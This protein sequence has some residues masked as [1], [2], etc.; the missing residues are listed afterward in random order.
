MGMLER[1]SD[2]RGT[3][4]GKIVAVVL[5]ILLVLPVATVTAF[6]NSDAEEKAK[7]ETKTEEVVDEQDVVKQDLEKPDTGS[8]PVTIESPTK[9]TKAATINIKVTVNDDTGFYCNGVF[10]AH[11]GDYTV[12]DIPT[13]APLYFSAFGPDNTPATV[14]YGGVPLTPTDSTGTSYYIPEEKLDSRNTIV[15]SKKAEATTPD[16]DE[17]KDLGT[18]PGEGEGNEGTD[19]PGKNDENA[20]KLEVRFNG[21]DPDKGIDTNYVS[22]YVDY[23]KNG[24]EQVFT[25][26]VEYQ[27][28]NK[29]NIMGREGKFFTGWNPWKTDLVGKFTETTYS[30][31]GNLQGAFELFPCYDTNPLTYKV[32]YSWSGAEGLTS[33]ASLTDMN[34]TDIAASEIVLP[35]DDGAYEAGQT[36]NVNSKFTSNT[37]IMAKSNDGSVAIYRFSGWMRNGEVVSGVQ[38]VDGNVVLSGVWTQLT[39][40]PSIAAEDWVYDGSTTA[41]HEKQWKA[42]I[43]DGKNVDEVPPTK[44]VYYEKKYVEET[45]E[46]EISGTPMTEAPKNA[47]HYVVQATWEDKFGGVMA[48]DEFVIS[49]RPIV[50]QGISDDKFYDGSALS[51]KD[52]SDYEACWY[53]GDA[54]QNPFVDDEGKDIKVEYTAELS[55]IAKI[56]NSFKVVGDESVLRN[57]EIKLLPGGLEIKAREDANKITLNL[58]TKSADKFYN[59]EEQELHGVSVATVTMDGKEQTVSLT[60][61]EA[62]NACTFEFNG[63]EFE[64]SNYFTGATGKDVLKNQ[65]GEVI[66]YKNVFGTRDNGEGYVIKENGKVVTS[67]FNTPTAEEGVLRIMPRPIVITTKGNTKV[68]DGTALTEDDLSV[69]TS[70]STITEPDK[71]LLN[72]A[73]VKTTGTITNV[74][75]NNG[76]VVGVDNTYEINPIYADGKTAFN[77]NNYDI[78]DELGT[79]TVYPIQLN[80]LYVKKPA[81]VTYNGQQQV[82]QPKV[83]TKAPEEGGVELDASLF[84][85]AYSREPGNSKT[86]KSDP[87]QTNMKDVQVTESVSGEVYIQVS[88]KATIEFDGNVIQNYAGTMTTDFKIS[89]AQATIHVAA[90]SKVYGQDDPKFEV[91]N[92]GGLFNDDKLTSDENIQV[93]RNRDGLEGDAK[94]D[95]AGEYKDVLEATV[96]DESQVNTNYTYVVKNGLFSI[97]QANAATVTLSNDNVKKVYDGQPAG[98]E[99]TINAPEGPAQWRLEYSTDGGTTWSE[100]N[101]SFTNVRESEDGSLVNSV[102]IRAM[103]NEANRDNFKAPSCASGTVTINPRPI[104]IT[105]NDATKVAGTADPAFDGSITEGSL[106]EGED[107]GLSYYRTNTDEGI[108]TYE[109]VLAAEYANMDI[110]KNYDITMVNGDF[111][112]TPMAAPVAPVTPPTPGPLDALVTTVT[113]FLATPII[114]PGAMAAEGIADGETPLAQIGDDET[115]MSA[116]DH[117]VCWIH[118]YILL[119]III[120]AIYGGGVIARRLG[121]N[122]TIKKYED[123]VTGESRNSE[124]LK[125]PVAKEGTQP[126]I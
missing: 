5:A 84:E 57:Y 52:R 42:T 97:T 33:A 19:D 67:Q 4:E 110:V 27:A 18:N 83:Y 101:P 11:P 38:A 88:G 121:Y 60:E 16:P 93:T 13:D 71:V 72:E 62:G 114:G 53:N 91:G 3:L 102:I 109:D 82:A 78:K 10:Q 21:V 20:G 117:P 6:A 81:D 104:T 39:C 98:L 47:G 126:T 43:S 54:S 86:Y 119:G 35:V 32:T 7:E 69:M 106:V 80:S 73:E 56:A 41:D 123:D 66:G 55:E 120:T 12:Y 9:E 49:P 51:T 107:L 59:G 46:F 105:V 64:L 118:Y 63:Q 17:G 125:K 26:P 36:F 68:Y 99:A 112:I 45:G 37:Q 87:A 96:L 70:A 77:R 22:A 29:D 103:P 100:D 94:Y 44:F 14:A 15:V 113:D 122:H 124:P 24:G 58:Q 65:A 116:F 79:L 40:I 23:D 31:P 34:G 115:P 2:A 75:W 85:F 28:T 50:I 8:E 111:T 95:A 74:K 61:N 89:P 25:I 1:L 30:V 90:A 108:G 48:Q 92:I 76:E